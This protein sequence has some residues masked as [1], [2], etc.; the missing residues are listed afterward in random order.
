M[1]THGTLTRWNDDRGFGFITPAKA[2]ADIFVH[3]SEFPR[4][5]VRPRVNELISFEVEKG[6]DGR[7][8]A[9]RIMRPGQKAA[10]RPASARARGQSGGSWISRALSILV[11]VAIGAYGYSQYSKRAEAESEVSAEPEP[12]AEREPKAKRVEVPAVERVSSPAGGH[13]CDGRTM[14]S[15]MHSCEEATYFIRNCP[16]TKMDGNNDGVPCEQQW[17]N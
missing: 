4:D 8:K 5:G 6:P 3:V 9:V 7:Q 13:S 10:S 14:C 12:M 15:Q 2:S 17:C 11:I 1:R 16:N